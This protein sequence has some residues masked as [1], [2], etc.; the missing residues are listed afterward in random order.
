M[1]DDDI[2]TRATQNLDQRVTDKQRQL[3]ELDTRVVRLRN[4][5]EEERTF[6]HR[7]PIF[8]QEAEAEKTRLHDEFRRLAR[9]DA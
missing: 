3:E 7:L 2:L 9:V 4:L 8:V 1:E 5:V 6:V